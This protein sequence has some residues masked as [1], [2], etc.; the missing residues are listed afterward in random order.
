M[1]TTM[2]AMR[3]HEIGQPLQ[4]DEVP[5]PEVGYD[6][7]LVKIAACGTQDGDHQLIHG[8]LPSNMRPVTIGHEP[9]GTVAAVGRNVRNCREGDRVY[10]AP[11]ISC[12]QCAACLSDNQ[13]YCSSYAVMGMTYFAPPGRALFE[14]YG[15]GGFA[16]YMLVPVGN[17][18]HL[19]ADISFDQAAKLAFLG[20][21]VKAVEKARLRPGE[22][23]L[24]AGASGALG[25]CTVMAALAM[26]AA[27]VI[28]VAR[29][30]ERLA[31]VKA[32]DPGRVE[33]VST[34]QNPGLDCVRDLLP[35]PGVD[36]L[37]DALPTALD[38]TKQA[39]RLLRKGGRAV[40]I[41]GVQGPL[42]IDYRTFML[43]EIEVTGSVGMGRSSFPRLVEL[44]RRGVVDFANFVTHRFPLEQAN[45]AIAAVINKTG[46][47]LGVVVIP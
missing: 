7:V 36:V 33:T 3:L 23:V 27:T 30:S 12:G 6:D 1:T 44:V 9:V 8:L 19:P 17:I 37:I 40:L 10:I 35:G 26:G 46:D 5:I 29:D 31:R 41:G 34:R 25:V 20:V 2:R 45:E 14:R 47:P 32:L 39:I 4:I 24:V 13:P 15:H 22:S 42:D 38:V 43:S 28:A 16:E 11:A 21:A 18:W